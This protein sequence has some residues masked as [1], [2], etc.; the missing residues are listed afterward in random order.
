MNVFAALVALVVAA[1]EPPPA[2][3]E[4]APQVADDTQASADGPPKAEAERQTRRVAAEAAWKRAKPRTLKTIDVLVN[5][6]GEDALP[7]AAAALRQKLEAQVG[8]TGR[9]VSFKEGSTLWMLSKIH[10][11]TVQDEA[12]KGYGSGPDGNALT[13]QGYAERLAVTYCTAVPSS[14][15]SLTSF[16][17]AVAYNTDKAVVLSGGRA[18]FKK[19]CGE[20]DPKKKGSMVRQAIKSV[21]VDQL[22][23]PFRWSAPNVTAR[24]A[25]ELED[26]AMRAAPCLVARLR[27]PDELEKAAQVLDRGGSGADVTTGQRMCLELFRTDAEPNDKDCVVTLKALGILK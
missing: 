25:A 21:Q 20:A 11:V 18:F 3:I 7:A 9:Y 23:L 27:C 8:D 22:P 14:A 19:L 1:T 12:S 26:E 4:R 15:V 10:P 2:N 17:I 13:A 6:Y 24:P 16:K 5:T